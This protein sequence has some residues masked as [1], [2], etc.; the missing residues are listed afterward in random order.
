VGRSENDV[1]V[2]TPEIGMITGVGCPPFALVA[3]GFMSRQPNEESTKPQLMECM[4]FNSTHPDAEA[5][6]VLGASYSD[7]SVGRHCK[8]PKGSLV[9]VTVLV[10]NPLSSVVTTWREF[11]TW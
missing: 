1:W 9:D 6:M 7:R 2:E 5:I 4:T 8:D 3:T 10:T 11:S